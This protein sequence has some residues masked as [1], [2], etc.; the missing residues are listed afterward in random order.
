MGFVE[1]I[2]TYVVKYAH[3]YGILVHSPIIA[4]AI[5]ESACGTSNK[6]K[7]ALPNGAIEWRHNYF[8]LKWRNGRCA[9]SNDYFEEWTSE[10]NADGS[11]IDIVSR[12][13]KFN[14]LEDCVVG[15]FQWTNIKNYASLKGVT[16]PRTYLERIKAAGYATSL[17]YVDNLMKVIDFYDLTRFD[18]EVKPMGRKVF[19]SAGHGGSDPGATAYGLKEKD[20]NLHTLLACKE[21]LERHGVEVIAS[22]TNDA[23]DPVSQ[24]VNEANA[25][26]ADIAVSFHANAGGGDGFEAFYYSTNA[27]G[28]KLAQLGEKHVKALGQNSRGIK[29]GNHLKFVRATT[30]PAV[31]FESFFVDNANDKTIG[32]TVEEQRAFGVAYAKAILE[33]LNIGYNEVKVE[34]PK[35]E[36]TTG[37]ATAYRVQLGYYRVKANAEAMAKRLKSAGFDAIIKSE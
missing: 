32:D 9:I 35:V 33:Y 36:S 4:Q 13:C 28:K 19:L 21:E 29:T 10:Q 5:L 2:A 3:Q 31:L 22:R 15:Y 1:D 14:S 11:Y 18:G 30:M 7:V 12:F 37:N 6:V 27:L 16:D 8:G 34:A 23:D 25:S 24:E 20:I 26:G 17:K